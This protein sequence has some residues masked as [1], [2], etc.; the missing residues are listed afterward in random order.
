MR[1]DRPALILFA[2]A[3]VPGEAKTRLIPALGAAGAAELY[4]CFL[5]DA[6]VHAAALEA[7]VIVAAAEAAHRPVLE[8]FAR[9]LCPRAEF[10]VQAGADLGERMLDAFRKVLG[11]GY[12]GAVLLGTDVPSLPWSRV[13]EAL[14]LAPECDLVL[15]PSFD[16]GYYLIGAHAVLPR[17][18]EHVAWGTKTVLVDTLTRGEQLTLNVTLL[19]PWYDVDTPQDLEVLSTHLRAL[20]LAHQ[21]IPC[22][23]TWRYLLTRSEVS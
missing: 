1:R 13:A 22:P 9:E 14:S 20:A 23:H 7:G 4:H 16:G 6:L 18:F 11:A 15:G 17:L 3:P 2:R 21:D 8:G 5:L 10:M 12:P 19:E